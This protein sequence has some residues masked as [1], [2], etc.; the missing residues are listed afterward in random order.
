MPIYD[1]KILCLHSES[2]NEFWSSII[3][4]AYAKLHGFW[5]ALEFGYNAE[6]F[7]DFTGGISQLYE[8]ENSSSDLFEILLEAQQRNSLISCIVNKVK[9]KKRKENLN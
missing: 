1:G 4:K 6:A 9:K 7:E 8:I 5:E 3:E 2:N